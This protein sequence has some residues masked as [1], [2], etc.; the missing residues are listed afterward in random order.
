MKH[1]SLLTLVGFASLVLAGCGSLQDITPDS[2]K[3]VD[4]TSQ[5]MHTQECFVILYDGDNFDEDDD[6]IRIDGPGEF[7]NLDSL[8][9]ADDKNWTNEAD[10]LKVG[11]KAALRT[12]TDANFED[13]EHS[14][15][16]GEEI[17][18]LDHD[19]YSLK[20]ECIE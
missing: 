18:D 8:D 12:R 14:Y 4:L 7:A 2:N 5:T 16:P 13:Q 10:S 1:L 20:I 9:N 6:V 3:Q 11:N 15:K 19:V 17:T